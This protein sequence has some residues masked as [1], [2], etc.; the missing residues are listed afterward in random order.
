M[1]HA[2]SATHLSQ[3]GLLVRGE[4]VT[5][6][7]SRQRCA[8]D[9]SIFT[10]LPEAVLYPKDAG[11]IQAVLHYLYAHAS[12]GEAVPSV[13]MRGKGS[14]Q[15][16]GPLGSGIVFDTT[17]HLNQI[18]E[19]DKDSVRVQPGVRYGELQ[20]EL[21]KRGRYL[22]P[23]PASLEICTIGGA[24]SNNSSGEKT[25]K[26]GDTRDYVTG[27]KVILANGE[28]AY[29]CSLDD[30]EVELKQGSRTFEAK[31]YREVQKLLDSHKREDELP[32][33][34]VTKNATGYCVWGIESHGEFNL[35][36]LIVGSQGTLGILTEITLRTLP[37]PTDFVLIAGYFDSIENAA[38]ATGEILALAPSALEIVDKNL[39]KL[40]EERQPGHLKGLVPEKIPDIVLVIEFDDKDDRARNN[41]G[42]AA[43]TI[44]EK[45]AFHHKEETD[46]KQQDRLW[47]L[48]RSSAAV[49]WTVPGAEKALPIVE[50][51]VVPPSLLPEFFRRAYALFD[52]YHLR[53]AIWGHAGD[54][55]LHMQPFMNLSDKNDREKIWP[56][57]EEFH[58]LILDMGG[59]ISAEH[60]DGLLRSPYIRA[61]Y[62]EELYQIF[63]G[64]KQIFDPYHF[65]NPGKKIDVTLESIKP[66]LRD[67]YDLNHLVKDA[68]E[69]NR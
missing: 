9:G 43:K 13:T 19:F 11:D 6:M 32:A 7:A 33:F 55:N 56:F 17:R 16:G 29:F 3:I 8:F 38:L 28:E 46:Q 12:A 63:R 14:D 47:D 4:L 37:F 61:Q 60:N 36:N 66:L 64:I 54:A 44:L 52:K 40:V 39:L 20:K 57:V 62:G 21:K 49:I 34:H 51:G 31:I 68:E 24:V 10:I 50:D 30:G 67:S 45:Y 42:R 35:A 26:Y 23:Y 22:P 27:L 5:D 2:V 48:R 65:L 41:K 25:V 58:A 18:L 53:I 59:C 1:T 69:I 15:A